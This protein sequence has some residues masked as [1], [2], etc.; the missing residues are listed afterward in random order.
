MSKKV[1]F[2]KNSQLSYKGTN[3]FFL[4]AL[5]ATACDSSDGLK[6]TDA[7]DSAESTINMQVAANPGMM[8]NPDAIANTDIVTVENSQLLTFQDTQSESRSKLDLINSDAEAKPALNGWETQ[9]DCRVTD[10]M[11]AAGNGRHAFVINDGCVLSQFGTTKIEAGDT[12]SA[13]FDIAPVESNAS[14]LQIEWVAQSES[15]D[16][17]LIQGHLL[18]SS[19]SVMDWRPKVS[20]ISSI[21]LEPFIGHRIG[22]RLS[23]ASENGEPVLFDA[24]QTY[25]HSSRNESKIA[26]SD[27]WAGQCNQIWTGSSYW[28]NRLADWEVLDQRLVIRNA[29][30]HKPLRTLHRITSE[31]ST[32]IGEF[33][34]RVE[35]GA[36]TED[37]SGEFSGIL[38]GSG[39]RLD[40]RA[41]A[42]VHNRFG[43][44]GGL[45]VGIDFN[46]RVFIKDNDVA[47]AR[48][49]ES[50]PVTHSRV[51]GAV[52]H[53][54]VS[55][56]GDNQ[57]QL[58]AYF[59]QSTGEVLA[60]ATATVEAS[61]VIGNIALVAGPG[62][63]NTTHWFRS[64][65]GTGNKLLEH[66][67]R[68][69]GPVLFAAYTVSRD[70]LTVN[71]QFPPAC[72]DAFEDIRLQVRTDD[73]SLWK[74]I[75]V[76]DLDP[77]AFV[78]RFQVNNWDS[79]L[80]SQ[81]RI[82]VNHTVNGSEVTSHYG[83]LIKADP[84]D[85]N[86]LVI[87]VFNCRPGLILS[88]TEGWIQQNNNKPFT[89][90][91]ERIVMPHEELLDN[92]AKH[93]ADLLA[94][95]GDQIYEFD[96]NGW[97][98]R[99]DPI[100]LELDY[101]WKWFQFGWSV[102][103]QT[104]NTPAFII[105]DDHDV[106]Q[107]NLWGQGGRAADVESA[108]GY[109]Q[110]AEFVELVQRTQTGSLPPA[111]DPTPVEQGIGVY[112]T[113]MVY[114]A[115]G[116]AVLEDRKFKT[117]PDSSDQPKQL[118]G[119]RQH[120]FL[121]NWVEDWRAQ[122]MKI[123]VSQSPFAQSS[124]HSSAGLVRQKLDVDSNG[125]PKTG[126]DAALRS[127]RRVAAPHISGDQHLGM[128]LRHGIDV[129]GDAIYSFASPSML[130][131][132]PRVWDPEN[133][134]DGPGDRDAVLLGNSIDAHGNLID[135]RAVANPDIY[136]SPTPTG[137]TVAKDDLGIG[138]GIV[139]I[140]KLDRS[141][142]F[143]A[144][145]ANQDPQD[146]TAAPYEGWP[147]T[148]QQDEND[149][150]AVQGFLSKRTAAAEQPIVKVFNESD[151]SLVYS[152]R[153]NSSTVELPVY[154]TSASYRVE[155]SSDD[156]AY[157]ELYDAQRTQ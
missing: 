79:S 137:G 155:F 10:Q 35:T 127:I 69:F 133:L 26:F 128:M 110:S 98:D 48:I 80:D 70:Q 134:Q 119:D 37:G 68:A 22:L 65:S 23:N 34:L 132:F 83:G 19:Q 117:G 146:P 101:F 81:Y 1:R 63:G 150:R 115:V 92:A 89:F 156:P 13:I 91:K 59:E 126:R 84:I 46:G 74:T 52:L 149:G 75:T 4:I 29:V 45:I 90:T 105:P 57:Y 140:N 87:G 50:E 116:I 107:G 114:G 64:F 49:A 60:S 44:N 27:S 42:L 5:L 113:D 9:G 129:H 3:W 131:V 58:D 28:A 154:D 24:L 97:I 157:F 41:A 121:D 153:W 125:W 76:A 71:A 31:V 86:E 106:Y 62:T 85:K 112:Y 120:A 7:K 32:E 109:V 103:E 147:V 143:E 100:A 139:R 130:N 88:D 122:Q 96:P 77:K 78:T 21:D 123:V 15:G 43:K 6:I 95:V 54:D 8:T 25:Q 102:R 108:G 141:Y 151:N 124:S 111:F 55:S 118:L 93:D 152:R 104:L 73:Q 38:I 33:S 40:H 17:Q 12:F 72:E 36:D 99:S 142:T 144:W 14:S 53:L 82:V 148:V 39:T 56:I 18:D 67:N 20:A 30:A 136:F 51:A 47:N 94:F 66:R 135:V 2:S 138:Y 145:P 11:V 16:Q 61:R